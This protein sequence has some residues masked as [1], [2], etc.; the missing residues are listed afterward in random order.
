[1]P[2]D[3]P[4]FGNQGSHRMSSVSKIFRPPRE[5]FCGS[6][7]KI[8]LLI[9]PVNLRLQ[10]LSLPMQQVKDN[11]RIEFKPQA[12]TVGRVCRLIVSLIGPTG[13]SFLTSK[14]GLLSYIAVAPQPQKP[15]KPLLREDCS[16]GSGKRCGGDNS[17]AKDRQLDN[18]E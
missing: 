2:T 5:L 7:L 17:L 15:S 13:H 14:N 12:L 11:Q 4:R 18:N 8:S 3:T 1:M 16:G 9:S 10:S 6:V